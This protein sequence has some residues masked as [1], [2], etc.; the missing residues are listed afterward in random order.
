M[1]YKSFLY[2][3]VSWGK[4]RPVFAKVEHPHGELFP[5]VG[6]IVTNM[7]LPRRAVVRFYKKRGAAATE[8]LAKQER[9]QFG[10]LRSGRDGSVSAARPAGADKPSTATPQNDQNEPHYHPQEARAI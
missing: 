4:A 7:T 9:G 1:E 6:F 5:R 2:P 10:V 3:A 8:R